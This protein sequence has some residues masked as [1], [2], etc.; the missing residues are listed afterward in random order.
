MNTDAIKCFTIYASTISQHSIPCIAYPVVGSLIQ[1][2]GYITNL[3][4]L[5]HSFGSI[6][7]LSPPSLIG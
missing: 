5:L 4:I 6:V 1:K 2:D 7:V 3:K